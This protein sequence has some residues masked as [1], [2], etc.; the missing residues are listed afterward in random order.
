MLSTKNND[1]HQAN[2]NDKQKKKNKKFELKRESNVY[3]LAS[4]VISI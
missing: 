2:D 1:Q 4:T 3:Y